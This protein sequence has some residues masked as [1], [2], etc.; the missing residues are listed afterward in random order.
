MS[1]YLYIHHKQL[2]FAV[3]YESVKND[4]KHGE[5]SKWFTET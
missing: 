2:T 3:T 1:A 4:E 5:H